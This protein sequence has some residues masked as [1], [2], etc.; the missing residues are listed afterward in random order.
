MDNL[1]RDREV[2]NRSRDRVSCLIDIPLLLLNSRD[3]SN[4]IP[5]HFSKG[6]SHIIIPMPIL[7]VSS[8]SILEENGKIQTNTSEIWRMT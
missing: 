2:I 8:T 3:L 6:E 4:T 1:H 5:I 7:L